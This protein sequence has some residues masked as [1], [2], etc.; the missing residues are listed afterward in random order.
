MFFGLVIIIFLLASILFV[1]S[2]QESKEKIS[3]EVYEQLEEAYEV[4]VIVRLK[5]SEKLRLIRTNSKI[6]SDKEKIKDAIKKEVGEENVK[7]VFDDYIAVEVSKD[8]LEKLDKNPNVESI[9]IDKPIKAFLQDSVLLINAINVWSSQISGVNITGI[10]ETICILDTGINF[11]HPDLIGK[12][13]TCIID[14]F[15]KTCVENCSVADDYG[16][17]THVAGIAAASGGIEGVAIGAS[18]IGVKVLGS[19]GNGNTSDLDAGIDW[20]IN[21]ADAYNISVISMSLGTEMPDLYDEYCDGS[22][23]TTTPRIN[24]AT[25]YNISVIAATGNQNNI[26][27]IS[28]P[29]CIKNVTAVSATD[30][31][32][33]IASYGNRNNLT[34]LVAP[35]GTSGNKINSTKAS[36]GYEGRY[37]TS[38]SAPHVAAAFA[39]I[40]QFFRLQNNSILT[41]VEIKNILNN[42][43]VLVDDSAGSGLN[44]SR[45]DSYSALISLDET[46]PEV[47]LIS[48]ANATISAN[49]NQTFSCNAIDLRLSN[50]TLYLWNSTND[51]IN[52]TTYNITGISNET[53]FNLTNL[54]YDNYKWNCLAED[55][56]GN[57]AFSESN[58]SLIISHFSITLNFPLDGSI[59]IPTSPVLN[60]TSYNLNDDAMNVSFY[61][62]S[63]TGGDNWTLIAL[64]D[65]QKYSES[66]PAIFNSQTWWIGN[67]KNLLNIKMV[68]HEGD[69]VN[70]YTDLA[71]W[72]NSNISLTYLEN[73]S[74]SWTVIPGDHDHQTSSDPDSSTANYYLYYPELRFNQTWYWG[75]D[76]N[77]N[78]NNYQL[79]PIE[80]DNYIFINVD[81]CPSSDEITWVNDTLTTYKDRKAILTTHAYLNDTGSRWDETGDCGRYSGNTSYI[82]HDLIKNHKNLQIVLCG[83]M[84]GGPSGNDGEIN[85]TDNNLYGNQVY[86]MLANYQDWTNG[87][88]GYLRILTFDP[89]ADKVFVQTYSPYLDTYQTDAN[90][91]FNFDY[92]MSNGSF[93][94]IGNVTKVV[95]GS[96]AT[97][98][99][100]NLDAN[101]TYEWYVNVSSGENSTISI[102]WD[103][104]TT[105]E[106]SPQINSLPPSGGGGGGTSYK[107]YI[108]TAEEINIGY[109]K[110]LGKN[111][112]IKFTLDNKQHTLAVNNIEGNY[113]NL[114]IESNK[115]NLILNIGESKKLNLSSEAYYDLYVKLNSIE[116]NKA[117]ITIKTIYELV[118][119]PTKQESEEKSEKTASEKDSSIIKDTIKYALV[120]LIIVIV[121]LLSIKILKGEDKKRKRRR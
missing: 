57:S 12:N 84:H 89:G 21:N 82:W 119:K 44:F 55:E 106:Q 5:D 79:M 30:K 25:L 108:P 78:T 34:D 90:S 49:M 120:V 64:P 8:E 85:R 111:D 10:D 52:R 23:P 28:S 67:N 62:R 9:I 73:H 40:R 71:E 72:N 88:N 102:I 39:L 13:K 76:Y 107:I 74:V 86:Q 81:F 7:H 96:D 54:I 14:C 2:V 24:N 38:M 29:A 98:T 94:N 80:G 75:G 93:G 77:N 103:F 42:T 63:T 99:W 56:K 4:R 109:T 6:E 105:I 104:T 51:L 1:S 61:G 36:G 110:E 27:H 47:G 53:S 43:G 45:I 112:K 18:L 68:V 32:D 60:I 65:T 37:G 26:T 17:G 59:E 92:E 33:N 58:Y 50:I 15:E 3:E 117:N 87:G 16:H 114:T 100:S 66:Y 41:P 69:I 121:V 22:E 35:G 115:I 48:P 46:A 91:Q 20:C 118:S 113:F 31:S 83:H 101:T 70:A 11:S 19:S 116:N 97:Y 95:N